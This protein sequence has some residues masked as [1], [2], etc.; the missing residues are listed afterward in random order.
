MIPTATCQYCGWQGPA[1]QCGPLRN[2]WERVQPGDVMPAGECPECNV[3]AMLDPDPDRPRIVIDS[4]TS[5]ECATHFK[6]R[7]KA[8]ALS[9][10][11][12]LADPGFTYSVQ[13][14]DHHGY[15]VAVYPNAPHLRMFACCYLRIRRT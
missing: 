4:A 7:S 11:A 3:S 6:H 8:R 2:A 10:V 5:P 1:E 9:V 12:G 14:M 15:R 13:D